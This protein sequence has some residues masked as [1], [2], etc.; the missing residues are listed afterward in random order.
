MKILLGLKAFL[1]QLFQDFLFHSAI[2]FILME[3][4]ECN[5]IGCEPLMLVLYTH[6]NK[7]YKFG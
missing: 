2:N 4:E 1:M 5:D 6:S 7:T 3:I